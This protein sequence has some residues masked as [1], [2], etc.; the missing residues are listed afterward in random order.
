MNIGWGIV[1][2]KEC[3][4]DPLTLPISFNPE[5]SRHAGWIKPVDPKPKSQIVLNWSTEGFPPVLAVERLLR[6]DSFKSSRDEFLSLEARSS[7]VTQLPDAELTGDVKG[8]S[9][10]G[11]DE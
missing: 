1:D 8:P 6:E 5:E 3:R 10:Y 11:I 2:Q 4:N 7:I 9:T